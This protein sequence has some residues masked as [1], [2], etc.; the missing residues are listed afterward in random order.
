MEAGGVIVTLK[1]YADVSMVTS[2]EIWVIVVPLLT[3]KKNCPLWWFSWKHP[4]MTLLYLSIHVAT[5]M[6]GFEKAE[7]ERV[8]GLTS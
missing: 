2:G 3:D 7:M 6:C 5:L 1:K 8:S 4:T